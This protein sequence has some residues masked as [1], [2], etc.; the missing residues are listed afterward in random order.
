MLIL[1]LT[2]MYLP[3]Q[4]FQFKLGPKV[5]DEIA[6]ASVTK[7]GAWSPQQ[8]MKRAL[9]GMLYKH[10]NVSSGRFYISS[11]I[12]EQYTSEGQ[13]PVEYQMLQ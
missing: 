7:A 2:P 6:P 12:C 10:Q 13:N 1:L 3:K 8:G 9:P 4:L 5:P 11:K